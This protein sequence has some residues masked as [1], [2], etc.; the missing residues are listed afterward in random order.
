MPKKK[1]TI[2]SLLFCLLIFCSYTFIYAQIKWDEK[3]PL[4]WKDFIAPVD[5]NSKHYANTKTSVNYQYQ[6]HFHNNMYSLTFKVECVF[7]PNGSWCKPTKQTNGLLKHEQLHFDIQEIFARKLLS[8][9]NAKNYTANYQV[10]VKSIYDSIALQATAMQ[11][12]YDIETNYGELPKAQAKWEQL[13]H[14]WLKENPTPR[15]L[16]QC[17]IYIKTLNIETVFI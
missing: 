14:E 2:K 9:F 8:T 16:N 3:E 12:K 5:N 7:L 17:S 11:R 10:E 1:L 4:T 13:V 15:Q 6:L